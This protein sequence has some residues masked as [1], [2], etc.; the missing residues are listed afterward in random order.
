V[1]GVAGAGTRA[2]RRT[3]LRVAEGEWGSLPIEGGVEAA[4]RRQLEASDD[5]DALRARLEAELASLRSPFLTAESFGVEE[6][7]DP[8]HPADPLRLGA[9]AGLVGHE[10]G[11][12]PAAGLQAVGPLGCGEPA[13]ALDGDRPL[14]PSRRSPSSSGPITA[15]ARPSP[16][17][18]VAPLDVH[19]RRSS[20]SV[21]G[22]QAEPVPSRAPWW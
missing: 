3:R 17:C 12:G 1:F 13:F 10:Q 2:P 7:I 4:Y 8:R 11:G 21:D 22:R 19:R 9:R 14:A 16:P 15:G 6:I 5:P 20:R 18:P